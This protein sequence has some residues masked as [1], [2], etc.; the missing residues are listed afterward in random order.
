MVPR[1]KVFTAKVVPSG[2][3]PKGPLN[4]NSVREPTPVDSGVGGP[5]AISTICLQ[6]H[7][8]AVAVS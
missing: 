2:V 1:M 5:L 8:S 4:D 6:K 3:I 7:L